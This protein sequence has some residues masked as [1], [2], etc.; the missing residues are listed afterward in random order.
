M[1]KGWKILKWTVMGLLFIVL[2]GG[3]TMYLWNWL[4]PPIFNGPVITFWQA[5]GLLLLSKIL[6]GG[7]GG[8]RWGNHN[9]H[10]KHRYYDKLSHMSPE[11]R[12]K[13][14]ARMREK[15]CYREKDTSQG[16]TGN[17]NV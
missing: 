15:W 11:D 17:T 14:K 2:F 9:A 3:L 5:L 6:L 13:F 1:E 7:L 8:K 4:V 12:E 10:W 16:S